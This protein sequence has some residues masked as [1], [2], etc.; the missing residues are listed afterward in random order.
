VSFPDEPLDARV[1]IN[2]G[3][4][5]DI[6]DKVRA[7]N[8][9]TIARGRG[10]WAAQVD[11]SQV[12]LTVENNGDFSPRNPAGTY[13]GLIGR[14]TPLRVS[15]PFGSAYG[16]MPGGT[17]D[18]VV[19]SDSAGISIT[20]DLDVRVDVTLDNPGATQGLASKYNTTGDQRSWSFEM[21]NDGIVTLYWSSDGTLAGRK[22][23]DSTAPITPGPHGRIA[24]RVTLDVNNG[25][26]GYTVTFYT[27]ESIESDD[28]TQLGDTVTVSGTTA[29]F[30]STADLVIGYGGG[31]NSNRY[32]RGKV[33]ALA[34]LDGID[35]DVVADPNFTAQ[36]AGD[37]SFDDDAGNT[38]TVAGN[39]AV[40]DRDY[41]V[42]A[43][44]SSWPPKWDPSGNDVTT[45]VEAAGLTRRLG[46][47]ASPLRSTMTREHTHPSRENI[48]AYWSFEDAAGASSIASGLPGGTP[49]KITGTPTLA[50]YSG[51][52]A[53]DPL[54]VM[55]SGKF[56]GNIPANTGELSIRLFTFVRTA[57]AAETS[58]LRL[59]TSG[60]APLWDMRLTTGG[61][62][63]MRIFDSAGASLEDVT[64]DVNLNSAGF[65]IVQLDLVQNGADIDWSY[66]VIDFTNTDTIDD[67][68]LVTTFNHTLTGE[69][70]VRGLT[71]TVG[72]DQGLT[73]VIA[74][75]LAIAG[76]TGAFSFTQDAIAAQ[77]GERPSTRIARLLSE[78]GITFAEINARETGNTVRLGD[79]LDKTLLELLDEAAATDGGILTERRDGDGFVYRTRT[80][81]YA[82]QAA[83]ELDYAEGEIAP[84]FEPVDDDQNVRN[85]VT[86]S[87]EG[88]SSARAELAT[89]PLSTQAPPDGV[90]RYDT[91]EPVSLV[92]DDQLPDQAG[93]R[94]HLGTVDEQ[95]YPT[96]TV[97]L[98]RLAGDGKAELA[99]AAR[100]VDIGDR[101]TITNLPADVSPDDVSLLVVGYT[102]E[103][104]NFSHKITFTCVPESP[105]SVG[106]V[107][108]DDKRAAAETN[109]ST[110]SGDFD[111]GTDTSL[112][113]A[114]TSGSPVWVDSATYADDFPLHI[115]VS[116]V[117]LNVTAISGTTSPQTFTVDATP[118]NG[119]TK[120]IPSGSAVQVAHPAI[121]AL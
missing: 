108:D 99:A 104:G 78:E 75:H 61:D 98:A 32:L 94:L 93:W 55:G 90:G 85:D 2:A 109:A 105:W 71:A 27:G 80:S 76:D 16:R 13:Y 102:E 60:T 17:G 96:V 52:T 79:Q 64:G 25:A 43:E 112:T 103:L 65:C 97:D 51:W 22:F 91:S 107:D 4:W 113:V 69:T 100:A 18:Q 120:T 110:T 58:L 12:N 47:G 119:V 11:P 5:I 89:G 45:S 39:A 6:S 73:D 29:V 50:D 48:I 117:V 36:T 81:L 62:L 84:P 19:T 83:L 118:V 20:G 23:A 86:V 41:R 46:Q 92:S 106:V 88:G 1:E 38:W 121:V 28:W 74:G 42:L 14:N 8:G 24:I 53:S 33:H 49:M 54:P 15:L 111:A 116:G 66:G 3:G 101:I 35:G 57:V 77:N 95:R 37:D 87:R 68:T 59:V 56:V 82:Q 9:I 114:T 21:F 26:S 44:V 40:D 10:D 31:A 34:L 67:P 70:F 115:I 30:D 63:R 72:N 7:A